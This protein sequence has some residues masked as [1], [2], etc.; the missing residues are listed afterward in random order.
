MV[1][2]KLTTRTLSDFA[3]YNLEESFVAPSIP[4]MVSSELGCPI[5]LMLLRVEGGHAM[6]IVGWGVQEPVHFWQKP[7]KYRL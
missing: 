4:T 2:T 7:V 5:S 1:K 6:K 3:P